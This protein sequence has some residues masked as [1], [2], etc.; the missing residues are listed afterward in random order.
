MT[1]NDLQRSAVIASLVRAFRAEDL[2]CGETHVQKS[3]FLLQGLLGVDLGFDFILYKYGPFSFELQNHLTK[4][5]ADDMLAVKALGYAATFD[6]GPQIEYLEKNLPKTIDR[7]RDAI[8]FAVE[9]LGRLGVKQLEPL[10]TAL[11][12]TKQCPKESV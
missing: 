11:Y 10:A 12:F 2:F 5:R 8:N 7:T 9:H 6:V 4:M 3:V 1:M